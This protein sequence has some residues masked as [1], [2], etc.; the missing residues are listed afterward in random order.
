M[1]AGRRRFADLRADLEAAGGGLV[2]EL[3]NE[4]IDY[5]GVLGRVP[6]RRL[7]E[8]VARHEVR[9]LRTGAVRFFHAV[10]QMAAPGLPERDDFE[11]TDE[12]GAEAVVG[13]PR[14]A[15]L[16][17]LPL[18]GHVL[19]RDR[20]VVDDPEGWEASIPTARRMHG[21]GMAS[22]VMH[23]DLNA[24]DAPLRTP[25]YLRPIL[26]AEVPD[27][28]HDAREELP[29]DRLAVDVVQARSPG[30]SRATRPHPACG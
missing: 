17:G 14:I 5:H 18:S 21:T 10:G 1:T 22:V 25:V 8:A 30:S 23:G 29:R 7:L 6:A 4:E 27:W 19:L 3:I 24:G 15:I 13:E 26:T 28:V 16:D 12:S 2:D 11:S 9:W 20:I